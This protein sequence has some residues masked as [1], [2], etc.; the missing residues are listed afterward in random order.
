[1]GSGSMWT[2]KQNKQFE[3]A[4]AIYD[5]DT[6]DRWQNLARAVGGKSVE[7]VKCHYQ[8]LVEDIDHIESGRV[9]LP[10]YKSYADSNNGGGKSQKYMDD[11]E[12][13]LKYLKLH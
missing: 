9:P 6:P 11:Q 7:E 13:R 8:K 4:L 5:K 1:M 2:A 10:K 12:Q 3:D